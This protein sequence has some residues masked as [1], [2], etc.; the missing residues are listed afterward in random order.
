MPHRSRASR[1]TR[2]EPASRGDLLLVTL[3]FCIGRNFSHEGRFLR[4]LTSSVAELPSLR[5]CLKLVEE[6]VRHRTV[7]VAL[8]EAIE[9]K[10]A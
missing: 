10:D 5:M 6:T 8:A 9:M 3:D 7:R 4:G 1:S 2:A